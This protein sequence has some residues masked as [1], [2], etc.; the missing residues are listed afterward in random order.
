MPQPWKPT[1]QQLLTAH[2][3]TV[4]DLLRA[5]LDVLFVGINPGLYTAAVGHHFARPG[6]R[7]WPAMHKGGF[8]P[9]QLSPFDSTK[10]LDLNL[11][12]TNMCPR[13]TAMAHQLSTHELR[14]GAK[15]LT[16]KVL[17]YNP[18]FVAIIGITSYRIAFDRK[19]AKLGLQPETIGHSKIWVLPNPSGLNAHYQVSDLAKLFGALKKAVS[20][21]SKI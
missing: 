6:N 18:R 15:I 21:D 20:N 1:K 19:D 2:L 17:R 11:G 13:P 5:N 7:F 4:P 10:L 16:R 8:T 12:I 14:K 9:T 3:K